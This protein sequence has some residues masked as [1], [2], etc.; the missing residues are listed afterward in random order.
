[1]VYIGNIVSEF[2]KLTENLAIHLYFKSGATGTIRY[3]DKVEKRNGDLKISRK[4]TFSGNTDI[5]YVDCA[6]VERI[7][8]SEVEDI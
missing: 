7:I 4:L 1:M 3:N 8:I 5:I 6:E 2:H